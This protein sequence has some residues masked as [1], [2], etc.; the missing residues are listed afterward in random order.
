MDNYQWNIRGGGIDYTT[1]SQ[2]EHPKG[3]FRRG[4]ALH[5]MGRHRDA[6]PAL[7]R[8]MALQPK[9]KQIKV[10]STGPAGHRATCPGAFG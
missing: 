3:L 4:L 8:A 1:V 10:G 6:L 7:G 2:A 5:A 9:N